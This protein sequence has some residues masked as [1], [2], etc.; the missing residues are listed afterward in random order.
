MTDAKY[1]DPKKLK[2]NRKKRYKSY[3]QGRTPYCTV[4]AS[5]GA[6]AWNNSDVLS[7]KYVHDLAEKWLGD[8][9]YNTVKM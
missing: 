4:F 9:G 8:S 7:D 6:H 1:I 5:A 3:D 2:K